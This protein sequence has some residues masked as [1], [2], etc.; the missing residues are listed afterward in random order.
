MDPAPPPVVP[1]LVAPAHLACVG[2]K[3]EKVALSQ[4]FPVITLGQ[5]LFK[6]YLDP[7]NKGFDPQGCNRGQD[8]FLILP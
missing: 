1:E 4:P 3:V 2:W 8:L 7:L 5:G 6:I